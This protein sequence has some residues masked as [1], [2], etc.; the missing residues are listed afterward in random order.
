MSYSEQKRKKR[1]LMAFI[2]NVRRNPY[3]PIRQVCNKLIKK[4]QVINGRQKICLN[5]ITAREVFLKIT[6]FLASPEGIKT[7]RNFHILTVSECEKK[8]S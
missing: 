5:Q 7:L 6:C 3:R 8:L 4:G 1:T 2:L